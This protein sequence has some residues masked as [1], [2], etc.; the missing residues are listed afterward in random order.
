MTNDL[1]SLRGL[2]GKVLQPLLWL[3]VF[4]VPAVAVLAG[5]DWAWPTGAAFVFMLAST[6][7]W[8]R[9]PDGL[10]SRLVN[11]VTYVALISLVLYVMRGQRWQ[12][13]IH[14]YYFACLA[15]LSA[16]C[17]WRVILM[18]T[19]AIALHHLTLNF[20]LPA[21]IYPG[22]S[23]LGRVVLHAAIA[24][25]EAGVLIWLTHQLTW[26]FA[27][28]EDDVTTIARAR[29]AEV[30]SA[31]EREELRRQADEARRQSE[32]ARG[33]TIRRLLGSFESR[34][35]TVVQGVVDATQEMNELAG[36]L[37]TAAEDSAG[38]SATAADA[39][40]KI[41]ENVQTAASAADQLSMSVGGIMGEFS[42]AASIA[43]DAETHA[44][45]T[46]VVVDKLA[47]LT[48]SI[49]EIV[50]LISGI[51]SQTNLLALNATIEAAR[52]GD[53]GKGFAVVA[54]EVKSLADQTAQAT[55][56]IQAQI[57]AVQSE[58]KAAVATIGRT[59]ETIGKIGAINATVSSSIARQ[60]G[61][62]SAIAQNVQKA[63]EGSWHVAENL[64]RVRET[65]LR[66][67]V[68]AQQVLGAANALSDQAATLKRDIGNFIDE[69]T[70]AQSAAA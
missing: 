36:E 61:A 66:T 3:H 23:D 60:D 4:L 63:A 49:G 33:E 62:T 59:T 55:R 52:A 29:D 6:F 18:A 12:V 68:S 70:G 32:A 35:E 17:D 50:Q 30:K 57:D 53:A 43:S 42:Y 45:E 2:T 13:D 10:S 51:A 44:R 26:L 54:A 9:D 7:A 20:V 8:M 69:M 22:G 39:S 38:Q 56:D 24:L 19:V 65:A 27:K 15:I 16:Y 11:A 14:M 28:A 46:N 5:S 41:S 40:A 67:G 21:A 31:A 25:L 47:G 37:V 58:M 1:P 48:L 34:V 64:E